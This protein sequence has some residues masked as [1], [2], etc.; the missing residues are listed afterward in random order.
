MT[1]S[2]SSIIKLILFLIIGLAIGMLAYPIL[3]SEQEVSRTDNFDMLGFM[4]EPGSYSTYQEGEDVMIN[5]PQAEARIHTKLSYDVLI[6]EIGINSNDPVEM[7]ISFSEQ[8]L[9]LFGVKPM[10]H[11]ESFNIMSGKSFVRIQNK[12]E[13]KAII[14]LKRLSDDQGTIRIQLLDNGMVVHEESLNTMF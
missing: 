9:S 7:I 10:V 6:T 14:L 2:K 12:G 5:I 8:N 13:G 1:E 3:F 4:R 11:D